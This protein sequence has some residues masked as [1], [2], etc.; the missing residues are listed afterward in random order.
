LESRRKLVMGKM[1]AMAN[2]AMQSQQCRQW[3]LLDYFDEKT[4]DRCGVCD[5]C[6]AKKKKENLRELKDYREQV[7][8]LVKQK[9][10]TV[11]DLETA[12][13]PADHHLFLEVVRE[14][15]DE[16]IIAYDDFWALS[17]TA[18]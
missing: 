3:V 7:L 16:G 15:V 10:L 8:Y 2:Y 1:E 11:D 12:V 14:M 17:I 6:L 5:V 9:K 4:Y 13:N 18:R